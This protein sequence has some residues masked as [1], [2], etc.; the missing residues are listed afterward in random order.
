M[1]KNLFKDFNPVSS[2]AWKQKIQVDLKGAD[3]NDTLVW[4][5]LEGIHVRPTYHA[6]DV[7]KVISIPGH[8]TH[9]NIAQTIF[10]DKEDIAN[11]LALNSIKRGAEALIFT[12]ETSFEIAQVFNNFPFE[13]ATLY[14]EF[15]FL[16]EP[17]LLKLISFLTEKNAS[18]FYNID[19]L[20]NLAKT[21]NWF[22]NLKRDHEILEKLQK[23]FT[24]KNLISVDT[25]I[26]QNAGANIV[27]QLAYGLAHANEYIHHFNTNA[28]ASNTC[29]G[30]LITFK[31][32]TGSNYFFEIAK[33]RALRLLYASLAAAYNISET[34]HV[35]SRP[36]RRNKTL[37]D[38]NVNMLRTTTETMS[39]VLGG[40]NTVCNLPYDALYHKSNEFGERI[41]RNQLLIL[42]N[43]SYFDTV[44]NPADGSYYIE[45]ITQQLAEQA[46]EVFKLIEKGGGLLAQ[47]KDGTLQKKIKESAKKEQEWFDAGK[48]V[49]VGTNKYPNDAD[50]MKSDLELYPFVK[51]NARKTEIE[52]IIA[53]RLA[54]KVEQERLSHE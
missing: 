43:E 49:L 41:S 44:S 52:P 9:W 38:Y 45:T 11:S 29:N 31:T 37:Y 4:Q 48:L 15:Q 13:K 54:E 53:K 51:T 22:Y 8:P 14:F 24:D 40:A 30:T 7:E 39:A 33:I 17:F 36:S 19:L 1:T 26:Y 3:Y 5:S 12:A 16:E 34:C 10:I 18:V 28:G 42:K 20:G 50:R 35:I 25:S 32:A 27:Q 2:K 21:G 47:L 6:D 46:L 23:K